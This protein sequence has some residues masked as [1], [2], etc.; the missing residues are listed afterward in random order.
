[1]CYFIDNVDHI[2]AYNIFTTSGINGQ[3][4]NIYNH[5]FEQIPFI[6]FPNNNTLTNDFNK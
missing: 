2:E 1:M 4:T 5:N 3:P 6:E